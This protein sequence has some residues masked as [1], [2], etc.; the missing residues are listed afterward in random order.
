MKEEAR[1]AVRRYR[2]EC[3]RALYKHFTSHADFVEKKQLEIDHQLEI[4]KEAKQNFKG[5]KNV[6]E[7]AETTLQQ[8]RKLT[9]ADYDAERRQLV[10]PFEN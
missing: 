3:Y 6:L 5:A 2:M 8:L 1:E 7:R 9:I 10:I 4:V